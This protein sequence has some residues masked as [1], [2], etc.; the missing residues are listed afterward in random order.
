MERQRLRVFLPWGSVSPPREGRRAWQAVPVPVWVGQDRE[1]FEEG[2]KG[3]QVTSS[4]PSCCLQP[5]LRTLDGPGQEMQFL[6]E[7]WFCCDFL[8][9][10]ISVPKFPGFRFLNAFG[11]GGGG[12]SRHEGAGS[13]VQQL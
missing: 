3:Q 8:L 6:D 13:R 1:K 9:L 5:K 11:G 2:L 4:S 10:Q 12:R 7:S